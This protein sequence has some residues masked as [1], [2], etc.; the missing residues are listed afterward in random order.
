MYA[1]TDIHKHSFQGA[2]FDPESGYVVEERFSADRE[3]LARSAQ[4]WCGPVVAVAI[5]A[6]TGWRWVWRELAARGFEVQVAG[7]AAG[8]RVAR[9]ASEREDRSARGALAGA[10]LIFGHDVCHGSCNVSS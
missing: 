8:A 5:E 6:T 10:A 3:S 4:P 7:A 9:Q 2:V 1:A